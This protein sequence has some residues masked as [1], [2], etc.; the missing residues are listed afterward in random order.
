MQEVHFPAFQTVHF[1]VQNLVLSSLLLRFFVHLNLDRTQLVLIFQQLSTLMQALV[2]NH[3]SDS[4]GLLVGPSTSK[5]A[6]KCLVS[7][8]AGLFEDKPENT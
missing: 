2:S 3:V 6:L 8:K 7:L 5:A 4:L 1:V